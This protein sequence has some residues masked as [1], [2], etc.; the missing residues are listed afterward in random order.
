[1][2]E[3]DAGVDPADVVDACCAKNEHFR[4]KS[5]PTGMFR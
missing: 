3:S 1:V 5:K 2:T 4:R